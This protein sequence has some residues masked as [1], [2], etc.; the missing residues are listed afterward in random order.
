MV[1]ELKP[2][3]EEGREDTLVEEFNADDVVNVEPDQNQNLQIS[4]Q[5]Q[6]LDIVVT[7][8]VFCFPLTC[9]FTFKEYFKH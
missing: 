6:N 7:R 8:K 3:A 2:N 1:V 4:S 5:N 9:I